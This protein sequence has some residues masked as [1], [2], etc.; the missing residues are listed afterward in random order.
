MNVSELG[1]DAAPSVSF[2]DLFAMPRGRSRRLPLPPQEAPDELPLFEWPLKSPPTNN[3]VGNPPRQ[4]G[5]DDA[6][7]S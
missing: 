6:L 3:E 4:D 5:G 7:A 2:V 1:G